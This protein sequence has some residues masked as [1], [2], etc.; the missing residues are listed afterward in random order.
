MAD[1]GVNKVI[2]LG[3]LACDPERKET[4]GGSAYAWLKLAVNTEQPR[5]QGG[6]NQKTE[7]V[8]CQLWNPDGVLPYLATGRQLHVEGRLEGYQSAPDKPLVMSVNV[9]RLILTGDKPRGG[10]GTDE[11]QSERMAIEIEALE[12]QNADLTAALAKSQGE[13]SALKAAAA[14]PQVRKPV[15]TFEE[16]NPKYERSPRTVGIGHFPERKPAKKRTAAAGKG[17]T[18]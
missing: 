8:R 6:D 11:E 9:D 14:V 3:R 10:G 13:V 17:K 16:G 1:R 5:K 7:Y 2:L 15:G 4:S 12:K 18:R